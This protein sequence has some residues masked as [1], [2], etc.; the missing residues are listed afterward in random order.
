M[1]AAEGDLDV[2]TAVSNTFPLEWP[3]GSGVIQQFPELDRVAW[4]PIPLA[5]TKLVSSQ[6]PFLDRLIDVL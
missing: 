2:T 4:V 3:K 1:W 6:V 5:R